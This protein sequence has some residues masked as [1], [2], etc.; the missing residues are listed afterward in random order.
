MQNDEYRKL[1]L[2]KIFMSKIIIIVILAIFITITAAGVVIYTLFNKQLNLPTESFVST[3]FTILLILLI[4]VLILSIRFLRSYREV[5]ILMSNDDLK[6]L[7]QI[8]ES[9]FWLE[10]FLPS[11]IIYSG[12]IRV[13][14][15]FRQPDFHFTELKEIKIKASVFARGRQNKIVSFKTIKG[16]SFFCN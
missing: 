9:R 15:W 8:N 4:I 6:T 11:F 5:L 14:T 2:S 12:Q 3:L 13:F 10:K 16:S 7:K 1:L